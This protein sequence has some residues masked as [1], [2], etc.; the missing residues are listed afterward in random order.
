[1]SLDPVQLALTQNRLDYIT[2][3]MGQVMVRTARSPIFS[4]AHDFTCFICG[5]DGWLVSQADG[6]PIHS[7]GGGFA[8][9]A[10]LRDF[11]GGSGDDTAVA[12]VA[13]PGDIHE[14]DVFV[15]N[16]PWLAGGNHLPDWVIARPVF[17]DGRL[18]AFVCNRAH[19]SD[20]GGGAAGT[21][22]PAATETW[23]EGVRLPVMKL[24]SRG[25]VRADLWRLLMANTRTPD[26]LDGDLRAMLGSTR[27]GGERVAEFAREVGVDSALALFDGILDHAERRLRAAIAELPDGVYAGEDVSDNDCF[28]LVPVRVQVRLTIAGDSAKVD[29]TGSSAQIRGFKNSTWANTCSSVYTAFASFFDA[30]IPRNEG[31]FRCIELLAPEGSIVNAREGAATTMCTVFVAHEIIHACWKALG[32]AAPQRACAGWAKNGFG[33][34]AGRYAD[35]RRYVFYHGLAAAGAGAVDGRD[36]FN[37]MGHLCTL[38]GLVMPSVEVYEQLYPVRFRRVEFRC[39]GGGAG[40]YRGGTGAEYEVDIHTPGTWSFRGEGLRYMTG[41]GIDGGGDGA[42]GEMDVRPVEGTPFP[43]PKF[44]L[45]DIGPA[46]LIAS[47]PGGGGWGD[48]MQRP[49]DKVLRDV[50]DGLVSTRSAQH[51]Y[52]VMILGSDE[53]LTV[54]TTRT[55]ALRN[56]HAAPE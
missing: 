50:R 13:H 35:G 12:G 10:L 24:V 17:T 39:D 30:D 20:I 55:A 19:Q 53:D 1:M 6:I 9:R 27:I 4:Q 54:D 16:D 33:I 37:Q 36:G 7:G 21:Y 32:Q 56:H 11:G 47:S 22:N 29:F 52:G 8:A 2:R 48:P 23:A 28:D 43:A 14:G 41:Y 44:G 15:L 34:T 25:T 3:Q 49:V 18:I 31:T 26:L 38:G 40:E 51:D 5:P 45:R 46:T 42:A